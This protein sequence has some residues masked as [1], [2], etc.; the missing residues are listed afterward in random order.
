MSTYFEVIAG[1]VALSV[2]VFGLCFWWHRYLIALAGRH[3][4]PERR[5]RAA[6][7][8]PVIALLFV[9]PVLATLFCCIRA[10]PTSRHF[11]ALALIC[12]IVPGVIWWVWKMPSLA[13]LGYGRQR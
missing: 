9:V 1:F 3:D 11:V 12:S 2:Y 4:I 6:R 7:R 8:F 5:R 13:A 10:I